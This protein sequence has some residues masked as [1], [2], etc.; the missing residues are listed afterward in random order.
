MIIYFVIIAAIATRFIP[1]LSNFAPVTALA[2][3]AAAY[4]PKKQA[5][6]IPL[7][8]RFVSDIF[9]GFF[10]WPLM[11]A[12]YASHLFG[13]LLGLWIKR[14]RV[15]S[16]DLN[17]T[18]PNIG[19]VVKGQEGINR[20]LKIIGSSLIASAVFFVVTNFAYFYPYYP[21]NFSGII[22]AYANG[23]PFLRGTLLGDLSYTIALFGSYA[24]VGHLATRWQKTEI[25]ENL[26]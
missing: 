23:L 26:A 15:S 11:L 17:Q 14:A 16:A 4:L 12:V 10:Q 1:H 22:A 6:V 19:R 21:H 2:I 9:L 5:V 7:A 24:L 25:S 18:R 8:V 3:F 13:V 20:W